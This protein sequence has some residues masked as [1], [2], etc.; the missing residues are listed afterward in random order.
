M[1]PPA[2]VG[3]ALLVTGHWM[4][5]TLISFT[6]GLFDRIPDLLSAG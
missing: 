2:G 6:H 3:V 4:L 1:Q 5:Q